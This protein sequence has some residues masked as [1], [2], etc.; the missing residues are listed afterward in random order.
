MSV[1]ITL[2]TRDCNG[3]RGVGKSTAGEPFCDSPAD[4]LFARQ[5]LNFGAYARRRRIVRAMIPPP[6]SVSDAGSGI[7]ISSDARRLS[8]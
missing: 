8:M 1:R 2:S 6:R 4:L 5:N 3:K 7:G